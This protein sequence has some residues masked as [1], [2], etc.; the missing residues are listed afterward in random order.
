MSG[1]QKCVQARA[2]ELWQQAGTPE[3]RSDEFWVAAENELEYGES[4]YEIATVDGEADTFIPA[5]D[6]PPVVVIDLDA[7]TGVSEERAA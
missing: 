1:T 4:E 2:Y 6:E 7:P 5:V 3:G